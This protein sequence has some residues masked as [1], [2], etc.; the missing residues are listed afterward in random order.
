MSN[1][2]TYK[3]TVKSLNE[4]LL[5]K[6]VQWWAKQLEKNGE[7]GVEIFEDHME[8][9]FSRTNRNIVVGFKTDNL[10][11]GIAFKLDANGNLQICGDPYSQES[12]FKKHADRAKSGQM[13]N[14][15]MINLRAAEQH[16]TVNTQIREDQVEI[17]VEGGDQ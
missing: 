2:I 15:Y 13:T 1:F 3:T 17:D 7:S 14:S 12:E 9:L 8:H 16:A 11:Y 6:A 10:P 4:Q 5:K